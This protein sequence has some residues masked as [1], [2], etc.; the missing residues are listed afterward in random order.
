MKL[1]FHFKEFIRMSLNALPN[2][3]YSKSILKQFLK[4]HLNII[5][6]YSHRP[7]EWTLSFTS[8]N[9]KS[10]EDYLQSHACHIPHPFANVLS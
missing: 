10:V 3:E 8:S 1:K 7:S 6:L 4:I 2:H 5:L 9:Q